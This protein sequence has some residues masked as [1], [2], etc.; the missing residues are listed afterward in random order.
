M[1]VSITSLIRG[2]CLCFVYVI[3]ADDTSNSCVTG[4][5]CRTVIACTVAAFLANVNLC[6]CSL[7][8]IAVLSVCNVGAP[9]SVG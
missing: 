8:A 9:Y 2:E 5:P 6:S 4:S 3:I 1:V 7:C